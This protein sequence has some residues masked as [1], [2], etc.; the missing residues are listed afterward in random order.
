M[1][2]I[3]TF[4]LIKLTFSDQKEIFSQI[5]VLFGR[6][7]EFSPLLRLFIEPILLL[8]CHASSSSISVTRCYEIFVAQIGDFHP[9]KSPK[10]YKCQNIYIKAFFKPKN[11]YIKANLKLQNIYIKGNFEASFVVKK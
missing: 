3:I 5:S 10:P 2:N 8:L 1:I 4:D 11:I 7:V 9:K 6:L